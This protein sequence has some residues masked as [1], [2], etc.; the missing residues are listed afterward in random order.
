MIKWKIA[1]SRRRKIVA[2]LMDT[3]LVEACINDYDVYRQ[4][5]GIAE[6]GKDS[7]LKSLP[8]HVLRSF[9]NGVEKMNWEG[10]VFD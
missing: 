4:Y 2:A 9:L 10:F 3:K 6:E 7:G 5:L 8:S 1:S